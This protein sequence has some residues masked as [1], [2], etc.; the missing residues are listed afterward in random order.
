MWVAVGLD[1]FDRRP[2]MLVLARLGCTAQDSTEWRLPKARFSGAGPKIRLRRPCVQG[3]FVA[4]SG[5]AAQ[6]DRAA[7]LIEIYLSRKSN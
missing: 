1:W 5:F 6:E 2:D 3:T 7:H 4:G